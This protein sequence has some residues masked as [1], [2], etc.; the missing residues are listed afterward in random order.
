M[1]LQSENHFQRKAGTAARRC[2]S[3]YNPPGG[4]KLGAAHR[5]IRAPENVIVRVSLTSPPSS[6][7]NNPTEY[8]THHECTSSFRQRIISVDQSQTLLA[9]IH[10]F[11]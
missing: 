10:T 3:D 11:I 6:S 4:L 1:Q 2:V 5:P 9:N 8:T 7:R